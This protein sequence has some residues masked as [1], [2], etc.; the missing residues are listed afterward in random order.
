MFC[1]KNGQ[2]VKVYSLW[3]NFSGGCKC[4]CQKHTGEVA[5][6]C[7]GGEIVLF[8]NKSC[9]NDGDNKIRYFSMLSVLCYVSKAIGLI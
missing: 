3:C 6:S 9:D 8:P 7:Q 2:K 4:R 5:K 1:K